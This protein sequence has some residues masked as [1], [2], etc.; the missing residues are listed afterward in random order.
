MSRRQYVAQGVPGGYRIW[1]NKRQM[2]GR[3]LPG[4]KAGRLLKLH[5]GFRYRIGIYH[6]AALIDRLDGLELDA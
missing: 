3:P 1:D 2:V 6:E 4:L 5:S